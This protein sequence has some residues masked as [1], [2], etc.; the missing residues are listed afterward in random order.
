MGMAQSPSFFGNRRTDDG[1]TPRAVILG[2][3]NMMEGIIGGTCAKTPF[4]KEASIGGYRY[5]G[6]MVG[7][8]F[9]KPYLK[10]S[11]VK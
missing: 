2:A 5:E 10:S 9:L 4:I 7:S 6:F 1:V 3:E 11:N 8:V